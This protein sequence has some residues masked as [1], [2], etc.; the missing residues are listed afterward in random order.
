MRHSDPPPSSLTC[1]IL[2]SKHPTGYKTLEAGCSKCFTAGTLH[3]ERL[4]IQCRP[5][6]GEAKA[7]PQYGQEQSISTFLGTD[8]GLHT[9]Q[10]AFLA[11]RTASARESAAPRPA[12]AARW[13]SSSASASS[14]RRRSSSSRCRSVAA[15]ALRPSGSA[16]LSSTANQKCWIQD[17]FV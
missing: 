12:A 1:L 3:K 13:R 9:S 17:E 7:M 5:L 11:A 6:S 16:S 10:N 4:I 15:R 8:R 2:F 14:L